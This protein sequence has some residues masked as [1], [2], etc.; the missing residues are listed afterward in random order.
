M[1]GGHGPL[2]P[3]LATPLL[4]CMLNIPCGG[5]N[6]WILLITDLVMCLLIFS[7]IYLFNIQ[8]G[9]FIEAIFIM[10]TCNKHSLE[11][12]NHKKH[13][14]LPLFIQ[15]WY[16]GFPAH[17]RHNFVQFRQV[18]LQFRSEELSALNSYVQFRHIAVQIRLWSIEFINSAFKFVNCHEIRLW[19]KRSWPS[20][21]DEF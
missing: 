9:Q 1:G 16:I 14:I 5:Y 15:D 4:V 2:V 11:W 12:G 18:L 17:F 6:Y 7:S 8:F 20:V 10:Q 13:T 3:P 19:G 21:T